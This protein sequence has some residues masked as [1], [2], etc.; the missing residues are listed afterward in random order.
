MTDV[1]VACNITQRI[2]KLIETRADLDVAALIVA[3][4]A[5]YDLDDESEQ[6]AA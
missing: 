3:L 5:V 2:T 6:R 4:T 1:A